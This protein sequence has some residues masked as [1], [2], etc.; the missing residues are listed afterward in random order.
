MVMQVKLSG[1]QM[2]SI[3]ILAKVMGYLNQRDLL[4]MRRVSR[5]FSSLAHMQDLHLKWDVRTEDASASLSMFVLRHC[6]GKGE[7]IPKLAITIGPE[8]HSG[9]DL[10]CWPSLILAL[11]CS[12][13]TAIHCQS[14]DLTL[15]QAQY[16][17]RAAPPQL[18]SLGLRAPAQIIGDPRWHHLSSL[19]HLVQ[20]LCSEV[21]D[22]PCNSSQAFAQLPLKT[23]AYRAWLDEV[24]GIFAD[25]FKL[26]QVEVLK[27]CGDPFTAT[28]N[29]VTLEA[30]RELHL[31]SPSRQMLMQYACCNM[32]DLHICAEGCSTNTSAL[33]ELFA[34]CAKHIACRH[35]ILEG[36]CCDADLDEVPD[37]FQAIISMP[38]LSVLTLK[39]SLC[40]HGCDGAHVGHHSLCTSRASYMAVLKRVTVRIQGSIHLR[41]WDPSGSNTQCVDL[42]PNGHVAMCMCSA[43]CPVA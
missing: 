6:M 31:C 33:L 36:L 11:N 19:T 42:Q 39:Q 37:L 27:L 23:Y 9:E 13:L 17:L 24:F 22:L 10:L 1:I 7:S 3:D 40:V 34:E 25:G 18:T 26:P 12:Q 14:W 20:H 29:A 35:L 2:L 30:L 21:K 8:K 41:F 38:R 16:L 28:A 43:C 15:L 5:R 4:N 32:Q